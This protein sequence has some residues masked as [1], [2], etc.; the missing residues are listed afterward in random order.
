MKRECY[1]TNVDSK[2][3]ELDKYKWLNSNPLKPKHRTFKIY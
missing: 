1:H 3:T 2:C